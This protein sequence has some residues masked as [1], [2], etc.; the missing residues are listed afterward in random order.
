MAIPSSTVEKLLENVENSCIPPIPPPL[1]AATVR[2]DVDA[3]KAPPSATR[4]RLARAIGRRE[5]GSHKDRG[6]EEG[7]ERERVR[8]SERE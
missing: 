5:T 3:H 4:I 7:E 2:Q 8:G 1:S 6:R